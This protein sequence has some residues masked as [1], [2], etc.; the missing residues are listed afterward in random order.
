MSTNDF[1]AP[2]TR[3]A[4][5]AVSELTAVN[6]ADGA[7]TAPLA[8]L[9]AVRTLLH[10]LE[11]DPVMLTAVRAA[12]DDGATWEQIA[13]AAGLKP[14][15]ARWRWSGTDAEIAAR[16][17]AGRKRSVRPSSVP[18]DLPGLSVAEA[19]AQLGVS[20]QAVYLQVSRGKLT[21]E[22]VQLDD[23]RSYKRVFLNDA[24]PPS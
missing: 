5:D 16:A 13:E 8:R 10:E 9:Q 6:G 24:A 19:A 11:A 3:A 14:A 12:L 18:T 7:E 21:S 20:A 2:G 23:G 22:T 4:L 15:A 1:L 17:L